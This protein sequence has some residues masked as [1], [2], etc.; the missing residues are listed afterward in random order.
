MKL[1]KITVKHGTGYIGTWFV[2]AANP[3]KAEKHLLNKFK[4]WDYPFSAYVI[5]F[6][7]IAEDGQHGKPESLLFAE[8]A[9]DERTK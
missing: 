6:E 5:K 8:E 1:Y 4:E 3:A 2:V 9:P 7:V